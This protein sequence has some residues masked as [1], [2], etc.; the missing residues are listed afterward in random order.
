MKPVSFLAER[1]VSVSLSLSIALLLLSGCS[2]NKVSEVSVTGDQLQEN[3]INPPA[4]ARPRVWWHW[5]NGNITKDGIQKDLDWME[6]IGVGG[7]QNFD[8]A[9]STP[10][11]VEQRLVYMTPEWKDAF[12]F[13]TELADEKGLEMAIAG[14]PGW[15]ESGGPWVTPEQAMKKIVW[16]EKDIQGGAEVKEALPQPP[17]E[18]GT[19]QNI[20]ATSRGFGSS[21]GASEELGS[22]ANFRGGAIRRACIV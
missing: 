19:F 17:T 10:Q 4:E 9:L 21:V 20:K 3:F 22:P 13:A 6:R 14:S 16:S 1:I 18:T 11:A 2:E 8:A 15:S 7:F 5:M 12:R